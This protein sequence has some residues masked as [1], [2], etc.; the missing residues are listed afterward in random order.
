MPD[1]PQ[2]GSETPFL[3]KTQLPNAK[4]GSMELTLRLKQVLQ[5]IHFCFSYMYNAHLLSFFERAST[6]GKLLV[7]MRM[8]FE[9]WMTILKTFGTMFLGFPYDHFSL[10]PCGLPAPSL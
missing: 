6:G 3:G 5:Q 9:R 4:N 8:N 7:G 10:Y 2:I 1:V